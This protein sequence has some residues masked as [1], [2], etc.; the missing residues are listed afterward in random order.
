MI[1]PTAPNRYYMWT[2]WVGN[3]GKGGGPVIANDEIG[4]S[5]TTYPERLEKAGV[6]WK[7]YQDAG[8]GLDAPGF[9][10]WTSDPYIGNYGD[11]S[12][13]YF[14]QYQNAQPA[15]PLHHKARIGPN[16]NGAQDFFELLR[17]D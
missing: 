8:A 9:W 5:W 3:D 14:T 13:L 4:Y 15:R 17:A 12:V 10:G 7:I 6:S 1:G 11:N 16:P 2:G